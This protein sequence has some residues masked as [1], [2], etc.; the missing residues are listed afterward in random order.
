MRK[1]IGLV[2][3]EEDWWNQEESQRYYVVETEESRDIAT[4]TRE[5][6]AEGGRGVVKNSLEQG[7]QGLVKD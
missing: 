1:V 6:K 7:Y 3:V 5:T 4:E 2:G